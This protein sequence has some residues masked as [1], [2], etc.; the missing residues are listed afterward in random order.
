MKN[1]LLSGL[2]ISLAYLTSCGPAAED[3]K[4]S[5]A[6]NKIIQDSMVNSIKTRMEQPL[7]IMN[8]QP[9]QPQPLSKDTVKK[10]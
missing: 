7:Q 9:S 5:D 4:V 6:R 2:L 8:Q 1:T 3:R 10:R